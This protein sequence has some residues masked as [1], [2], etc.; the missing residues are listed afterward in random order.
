[1][2]T[3]EEEGGPR[4]AEEG[5]PRPFQRSESLASMVS[6]LR[7]QADIIMIIDVFILDF[8]DVTI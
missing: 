4:T 8:L 5:G 1:M 7:S 3:A 2:I 6:E